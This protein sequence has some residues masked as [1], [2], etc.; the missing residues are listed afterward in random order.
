M[1]AR[2]R[3]LSKRAAAAVAQRL[4]QEI[5]WKDAVT[6]LSGTEFRVELILKIWGHIDIAS[7]EGVLIGEAI[8]RLRRYD[9][10]ERW[11][12]RRAKR[13]KQ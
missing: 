7:Y 6:K 13:G 8:D 2:M 12:E 5:E 3:W 4:R 9:I 11:D 10:Q 1:E